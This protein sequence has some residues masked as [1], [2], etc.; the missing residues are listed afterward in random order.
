[1]NFVNHL[2]VIEVK[3]YKKERHHIKYLN[4]SVVT[5]FNI[6]E[7]RKAIFKGP[8]TEF[9]ITW[10][11]HDTIQYIDKLNNYFPKIKIRS[12]TTNTPISDIW[13]L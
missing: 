2:K 13:F 4:C 1:M 12:T 8:E 10:T 3:E 11:R 9:S 6:P 5:L 7:R